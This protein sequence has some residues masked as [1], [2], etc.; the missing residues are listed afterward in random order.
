LE[1]RSC[2][3]AGGPVVAAEAWEEVRTQGREGKRT[4]PGGGEGPPPGGASG[5][6]EGD[7]RRGGLQTEKTSTREVLTWSTC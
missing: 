1:R 4:G 2:H 7:A 5:A 6:V 3:V